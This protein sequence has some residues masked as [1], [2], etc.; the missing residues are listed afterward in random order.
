MAKKYIS[1]GQLSIASELLDFVNN[2]LLPGAGIAKENF[3]IG[4]DKCVHE[5]APKNRKLLEFRQ[6]LQK[7][8]DIWHRDKKG[9]KI[10]IKEYSNFLVDIG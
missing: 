1:L 10:G 6:N 4:L 7:K 5:L 2:E 3:W 9:E 8:I